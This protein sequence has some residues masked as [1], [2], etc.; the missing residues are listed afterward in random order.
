ML[1]SERKLNE[2]THDVTKEMKNIIRQKEDTDP[3]PLQSSSIE[4]G[5]CYIGKQNNIRHCAKVSSRNKCMSGDIFPT[6]DL[7]INPTLRS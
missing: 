6:M 2:R 3:S 4:Q 7:C 1:K 5:Y